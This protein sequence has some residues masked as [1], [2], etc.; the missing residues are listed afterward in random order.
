MSNRRE[1]LKKT[2][3][4]AAGASLLGGIQPVRANTFSPLTTTE[5]LVGPNDLQKAWM[6]MKFGM[7]I[8]FG[9]N[10][11]YDLEW[12]DGTLDPSKYNPTEL[13]TDQWCRVAADAGMKYIVMITKHHDGF[14]LWPS[15]FTDYSVQAT[16]VKT[17]VIAELANS[18]AKHGLKLGL[19]YSLWDRHEKT[20]D[21]DEYKYVDFMKNQL[22]ELLSR[23]GDVVELW[24]DGF[25]KKQSS[26]WLKP[27]TNET[28][29]K[30]EA[31]PE[32]DE[33]NRKFIESWR[34][35]GAYRWQMDHVYQ[36]IKLLQNNCLVMNNSTTAYTGVPL[37]PVD[38]LSGERATKVK[39]YQHV[40]EW[41]GKKE[42][43]PLQIETTMS[44]KGNKQF[45]RG[46]WFWHDWDHSV[47]SK[48][49]VNGWLNIAG[50][51]QANLLLNCGVMGNGKL[52]PEDISVLSNLK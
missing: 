31:G 25:W 12:S 15:K 49:D 6:A 38:I 30:V 28:G 17:D 47:A 9:I 34:M 40:W 51:M 29:D 5:E 42:Y 2:G 20:H 7:F 23:Y 32:T 8:H 36:Y 27:I 18:A 14:C 44:T 11:Y 13:D 46:N 16:S 1:F 26:G 39:E 10:T 3:L 33:R 48:E 43:L 24:F 37:H 41:L 50:Q 35:E 19:Y 52:R 22:A 45:P 21:T 4:I